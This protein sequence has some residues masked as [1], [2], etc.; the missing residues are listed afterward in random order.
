MLTVRECIEVLT[1]LEKF[2]VVIKKKFS[3]G[4]ITKHDFKFTDTTIT[5]Q[6]V[7]CLDSQVTAVISDYDD[8]GK[9]IKVFVIEQ[10]KGLIDKILKLED[11][12]YNEHGLWQIRKKEAKK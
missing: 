5:Q 10:D 4:G 7:E 11:D 8:Q 9:I 3:V 2:R 1:N 12:N 6:I